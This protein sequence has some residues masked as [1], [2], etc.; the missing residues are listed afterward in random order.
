MA[1]GNPY[2]GLLRRARI[3][4]LRTHDDETRRKIEYCDRRLTA[5]PSASEI[6]PDISIGAVAIALEGIIRPRTPG[7]L[8]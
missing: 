6:G 5:G 4:Y 2:D 8:I 1:S 3:F 7:S